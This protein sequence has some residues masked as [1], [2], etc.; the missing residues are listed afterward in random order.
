MCEKNC[1]KLTYIIFSL[2]ISSLNDC[3]AFLKSSS[4]TPTEKFKKYFT[5]KYKNMHKK[6]SATVSQQQ[7]MKWQT[8]PFCA[9]KSF[10]K[11]TS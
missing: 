8:L 10:N 9:D 2:S 6:L 11:H 1:T 7:G 5:H 4:L 3:S